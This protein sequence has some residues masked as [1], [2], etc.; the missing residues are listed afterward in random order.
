MKS[1]KPP[2]KLRGIPRASTLRQGTYRLATDPSGAVIIKAAPAAGSRPTA[3]N[4]T[5]WFLALAESS[6]EKAETAYYRGLDE[7]YKVGLERG[8]KEAEEAA[9]HFRRALEGMEM[10][11]LE[12]Y[13]G[14]ERWSVKLAMTIA[15]KV[16]G[17]AA[18]Q[19]EDLVRQTVR[20][21]IQE[22]ADRTRILVRVHPSDFDTL[23]SMRSDITALSEGIEHLRIEADDGVTP[24]SCRVET[25]SGL[26]DADF[27]TQLAELRRA[28]LLHEEA[29]K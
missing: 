27:T 1:S 9:V 18:D 24:G 7:G 14:V 8:R 10:S 4:E 21:A 11:L 12:F 5:D 29:P 13:A 23:K 26:L 20:R 2:E 28:L 22:T 25:P 19:H 3:F 6:W 16:I 15:E 17:R